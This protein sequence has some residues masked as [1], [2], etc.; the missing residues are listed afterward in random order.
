MKKLTLPTV[1]SIVH[2]ANGSALINDIMFLAGS[3]RMPYILKD[4]AYHYF[5]QTGRQY[6][7]IMVSAK[8]LGL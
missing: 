5:R 1:S 4:G 2:W 3:P 6:E 7:L 8:D